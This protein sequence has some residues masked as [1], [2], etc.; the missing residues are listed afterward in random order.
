MASR[1]FA[2]AWG[3]AFLLHAARMRPPGRAHGPTDILKNMLA[4]MEVL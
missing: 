1:G 3:V 4:H 2:G